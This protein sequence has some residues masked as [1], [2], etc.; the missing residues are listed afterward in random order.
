MDFAG[1]N[2]IQRWLVPIEARNTVTQRPDK[3]RQTLWAAQNLQQ[4][5]GRGVITPL[6]SGR[7]NIGEHH[8]ALLDVL[9][10]DRRIFQQI[11]LAV[12]DLP[13]EIVFAPIDPLEDRSRRQ[14]LER[15]AHRESLT[16][17]MVQVA[18][19]RGVEGK[20]PQPP[21]LALLERGDAIRGTNSRSSIRCGS[22]T[23]ASQRS[24]SNQNPTT[25]HT[26]IHIAPHPS[27][28]TR[29]AKPY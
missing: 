22:R 14:E 21:T 24:G 28:P 29:G 15:A 11:G 7:A 13:I 20:H 19:G 27:T 23:S 2:S 26:Q 9:F 3:G 17:T 18:P 1:T 16:A 25:T 4:E 8:L 6:N 10:A 12:L 5:I